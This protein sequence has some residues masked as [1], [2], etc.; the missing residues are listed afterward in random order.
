MKAHAECERMVNGINITT[1]GKSIKSDTNNYITTV[2]SIYIIIYIYVCVCV[3][4]MYYHGYFALASGGDEVLT[5]HVCVCAN[6]AI[7]STQLLEPGQLMPR[8][9]LFTQITLY[10]SRS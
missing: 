4:F 9:R 8:F 5:R 3:I 10:L 6:I 1:H 7:V 2:Y